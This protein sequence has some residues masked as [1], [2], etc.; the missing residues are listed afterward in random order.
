[1][2]TRTIAYIQMRDIKKEMGVCTTHT[3]ANLMKVFGGAK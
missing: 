2:N 3:C 1:M